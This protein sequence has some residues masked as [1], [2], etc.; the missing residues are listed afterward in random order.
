MADSV[1]RYLV[2][3]QQ[4]PLYRIYRT[5][6]GRDKGQ[7]ASSATTASS[8]QTADNSE[9]KIVNGVRVTLLHNSLAS[10]SGE[11]AAA[12]NGNSPATTQNQLAP[13]SNQ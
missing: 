1:A 10:M 5:G 7:A 8:G 6:L 4:V 13:A 9:T 11:G 3:E 2:T 12:S